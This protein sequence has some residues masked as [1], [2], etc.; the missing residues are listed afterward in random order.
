MSERTRGVDVFRGP[1]KIM[2]A[3][4]M[5]RIPQKMDIGRLVPSQKTVRRVRMARTGR[6]TKA[7]SIWGAGGDADSKGF[8]VGPRAVYGIVIYPAKKQQGTYLRVGVWSSPDGLGYLREQ[9]HK[10]VE[11]VGE[12]R[13]QEGSRPWYSGNQWGSL[14]SVLIVGMQRDVVR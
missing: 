6:M 11:V 9:E 5:A 7:A 13:W 8:V 14:G 1:L 10:T 2:V 4:K 3:L 12:A